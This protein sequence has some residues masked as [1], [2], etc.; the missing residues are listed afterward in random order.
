MTRTARRRAAQKTSARRPA[1]AGRSRAIVTFFWTLVLCIATMA[2]VAWA[3]L[4]WGVEQWRKSA[5][6]LKVVIAPANKDISTQPVI[7]VSAHPQEQRA[8]IVVING[9][10]PVELPQYGTYPVRSV[11]GL[12]SLDKVDPQYVHGVY[13]LALTQLVTNVWSSTSLPTTTVDP[14]SH[15]LKQILWEAAWQDHDTSWL[16]K[17]LWLSWLKQLS[18]RELR[19]HTVTTQAEW[20]RL[21]DETALNSDLTEQCLTAVVNATGQNGWASTT[22]VMLEN[23]GLVV[24]RVTDTPD[25]A[26]HSKL[27]VSPKAAERCDVLVELLKKSWPSSLQVVMDEAQT[28][29]YRA[30]LVLVVGEDAKLR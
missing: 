17:F 8:T 18:D 15:R 27:L 10:L 4:N 23:T 25:R 3:G 29:H 14:S 13:S 26:D 16:D 19:I 11:A 12:L 9:E 22:S 24:I 2:L 28:D 21:Q 5:S 30:S 6:P 1:K 20:H 7:F